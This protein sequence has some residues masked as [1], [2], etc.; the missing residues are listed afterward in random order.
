[1]HFMGEII[2]TLENFKELGINLNHNILSELQT[3]ETRNIL[4]SAFRDVTSTKMKLLNTD[5]LFFFYFF[6]YFF[7]SPLEST[8]GQ[9]G[10]ISGFHGSQY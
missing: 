6:I 9:W 2:K 5:L 8:K 7:L 3:K 1:M 10:M 4:N